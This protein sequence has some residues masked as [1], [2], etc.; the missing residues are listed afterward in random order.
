MKKLLKFELK[1]FKHRKILILLPLILIAIGVAGLLLGSAYHNNFTP[2]L[3]MLNVYNAY[4]QFA[5]LFVSYIYISVLTEDFS[6]GYYRFFEQIGY[7]LSK[8]IFIKSL[9]LFI[10][11]II[12]TDLFMIIYALIINVA[13]LQ[14]LGLM[15]ISVDLGLLFIL[16]LS[17]V[18]ALIFKKVTIAT[19]LSFVLYIV[20]DFANLVAYG[21]TNPCDANSLACVTFGQLSGL[22]LTHD[23][24]SKLNLNFVDNS[25]IFTTLPAIIYCLIL[26][27]I[28]IILIKKENKK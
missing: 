25:V 26:I 5:F 19:V 15:L 10:I 9:I 2:K 18:L 11:S 13:D 20:F 1:R 14:Y 3:N 22:E 12:V 23:S 17:N 21:L 16:L 7:S 28:N 6:K 24:L 4:S 27:G 8:C